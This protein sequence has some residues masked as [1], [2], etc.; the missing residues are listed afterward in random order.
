MLLPLHVKIYNMLVHPLQLNDPFSLLLAAD[1]RFS[2]A[3]MG[4]DNVW[5][6]HFNHHTPIILETTFGLRACSMRIF[7][8]VTKSGQMVNHPDQYFSKPIIE[9]IYPNY[10]SI[11]GSIFDQISMRNQFLV[12]NANL[13]IGRIQF[14]NK[15]STDQK[16]K[17]DLAA[18]LKPL[19]SGYSMKPTSQNLLSLLQGQSEE[20]FVS[21][22]M[23]SGPTTQGSPY[24][25]LTTDFTLPVNERVNIVWACAVDND[26]LASVEFARKALNFN[27]DAEVA[28]IEMVNKSNVIAIKT[29]NPDWDAVF[30]L[31]QIAAFSVFHSSDSDDQPPRFVPYRNPETV[32]LK[33]PSQGSMSNN[34][35]ILQLYHLS[36][37]LLPANPGLVKKL[38]LARLSGSFAEVKVNITNKAKPMLPLI[39]Q[40]AVQV[41]EI[42]FDHNF[43][44]QVF[45]ALVHNLNVWFNADYDVDQDGIPE[46]PSISEIGLTH[47]TLFDPSHSVGEQINPATVE[48]P[49]LSAL[50]IAE[51]AALKQ[52]ERV[53]DESK[54]TPKLDKLI[55]K[56]KTGLEK[57]FQ[58]K[59]KC[60][61]YQDR[62][63]HKA[64]Y[65]ETLFS[66]K[67]LPK[68]KVNKKF[69]EPQRL[70]IIFEFEDSSSQSFSIKI[71][72]K[73]A[74]GQEISEEFNN[75]Q[76]LLV[77]GKRSIT[78]NRVYLQL[79]SIELNGFSFGG[80]IQ[81]QTLGLQHLDI[82]CL[83]PILT[84]NVTEKRLSSI[85]NQHIQ[86]DHLAYQHGI[87]E[88]FPTKYQTE[89]DMP[90]AINIPW[91]HLILLGLRKHHQDQLALNLFSRLMQL[92]VL[93]LKHHH[94][95]FESYDPHTGNPIGYRNAVNG[96]IPITFFLDLLG[97][98]IYSPKKVR[99]S[100]E[101]PF[102]W[103]VS[104]QFCGLEIHRDGR[105]TKLT[106]P[107]GQ[108]IHHYG[109]APKLFE[110]S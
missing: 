80:Q 90:N 63:T 49:A 77:N 105:N 66:G 9:N 71:A 28:R 86:L 59:L 88:N 110:A 38:L 12:R 89:K 1:Q 47:N 92:S 18:V 96:L 85:I 58:P 68:I 78:S 48:S 26:R 62:D 56:T 8:Q 57:M 16:I 67:I 101:S 93:S 106:L 35:S 50:I 75:R 30:Y 37:V 29:G 98:K 64:P 22:V 109:T 15:S 45:P 76:L 74:M 108:T 23:S 34:V 6:L 69:L 27:W 17:L 51:Y 20:L 104:I 43:L 21:I 91:N 42:D 73:D 65:D 52:I 13:T 83:A 53:L 3:D 36:Q 55:R 103:P 54:A 70:H 97:V 107:N 25:S 81:V 87:P 41:Y 44:R 32:T 14:M 33:Q 102:P 10:A 7:S 99:I 60:F 24:P 95:F 79:N 4:V 31:S 2:H 84:E 94:A 46:L 61:N 40:L 100:G 5:E 82:S 39:A 11:F 72:G 19:N